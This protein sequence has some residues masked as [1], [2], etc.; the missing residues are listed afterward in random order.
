MHQSEFQNELLWIHPKWNRFDDDKILLFIDRSKQR[1]Q[2]I[3]HYT[4]SSVILNNVWLIFQC[5]LKS[6]FH[7]RE[8]D[9]IKRQ[10]LR[11]IR[12]KNNEEW[13][14]QV[15]QWFWFQ[16]SRVAFICSP[17]CHFNSETVLSELISACASNFKIK[18]FTIAICSQ[19]NIFIFKRNF[20][21]ILVSGW[22]RENPLFGTKHIQFECSTQ[23]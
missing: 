19:Q 12:P 16:R 2:P 20:V 5:R 23:K 10:K 8:H 9:Y 13:L 15:M 3:V 4:K 22:K 21:R 18:R 6:I 17:Q 14:F 1:L 7:E 11:R